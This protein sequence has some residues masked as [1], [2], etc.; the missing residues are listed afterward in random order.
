LAWNN[1]QRFKIYQT[2]KDKIAGIPALIVMDKEG[3]IIT[4]NGRGQI[5][6]NPDCLTRWLDQV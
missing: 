1:L 6:K 4:F 5:E 3:Q 2:L